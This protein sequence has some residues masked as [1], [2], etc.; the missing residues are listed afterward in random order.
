[1]RALIAALLLAL[2]AP[3]PA[4]DDA[5]V[6]TIAQADLIQ[7]G[8]RVFP[9]DDGAWAPVSL[10]HSWWQD[11]PTL[12]SHAWYRIR[13]PLDAVP[14]NGLSLYLPKLVVTDGSVYVN[15]NL[16]W[17]L[18]DAYASGVT[19]SPLRIPVPAKLLQRG[20][21]TLHLEVRAYPQWFH[22]LPRVYVGDTNA[23]SERAAIRSLLQGQM[24]VLVA[25]A[26]GAL[27]VLS[28][29]LWYR[30]GRDPV[31]FWYGVSGVALLVAT[32][33]WYVTMWRPNFWE[34]R[35]GL[36]F[37]R[38]HGYLV[39]LFILHL[40]LAGRRNAWLEGAAWLLLAAGFV[41]IVAPGPWQPG[42]WVT[43][44][45][46]FAA[47][48]ALLTIPLLGSPRLRTR[49]A[50][51]LLVAADFAA[52]LLTL[53]DWAT[54]VA[55]LDFE[56]PNL[57]YFAAPFVM[58]AAAVPILERMLA[59]ARA[60]AQ[61]NV[62]LERRVAAKALEIEA[63]HRQLREAQREQ[64]MGEERRRI[65]ADMHDGLG[66]RLVSLL[67]IAQSGKAR[68]GEI[69]EGLA[70]ALDE[71]RLTIDS[72]QPVKGDVGVVLGNVRHRMR[73]VF[74]RA[75][76]KFLWNVSAL[77]RMDNLTPERILAI[78]RIFL[79]VFS[80]ALK[81]PGARTV[82]VSAVRLPGAVQIVI[83]D[84][85]R[86]FEEGSVCTGN[87]LA[88]L[89][90]RAAQAGGALA[91]ESGPGSGT[92]VTLTLPLADE[93]TPGLPGTGQKDPNYPVQ[94]MSPDAASA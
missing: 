56:R 13:F 29:L 8:E 19:L 69:S 91:L 17:E 42:A 14:A 55:L 41:S 9:S 7:T 85:G 87:G 30:S 27:G 92:R 82:A 22:G 26:F 90:L 60:T 78:Q 28:L 66:S 75:G 16:V 25:A 62:E 58:L 83:A 35:L 32:L 24:I 61:M 77:P 71:L 6:L 47:L 46:V 74:E 20:T 93:Q 3:A 76:I 53:H 21:N 36:I 11:P 33:L 34:W 86:G 89:K 18:S 38:Y 73:S 51:L 79:E 64:E 67:S 1:V 23:L 88:N 68:H 80:N 84:D 57:T 63:N 65:M 37:M 15:R 50:V 31:L 49:P 5:G 45:L 2:A 52:A 43:W 94:G 48:P 54:R 70:A 59:G 40:R 10:P 4:A 12:G 44:G 81:H 39:P 72:V